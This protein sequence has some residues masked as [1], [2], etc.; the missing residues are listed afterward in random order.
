MRT[1]LL[2]KYYPV[3]LNINKRACLVAGGGNV[4][5]RKVLQLIRSGAIVKVVSP[6]VIEPIAKL[7]RQHKIKLV[8]RQYRSSDLSG[9]YLVYAATDDGSVNKKI[10]LDSRT[11]RILTNVV[12]SPA[13]CDFIMPAMMKKGKITITVSTDGFAPY[14][15]VLLKKRIDKLLDT[16]YMELIHI[17]IKV[18]SRLLKIKKS[19]VD[20]NIEHALDKLSRK[21]LVHYIKED[22]A[23]SLRRYLDNFILSFTGDTISRFS[24]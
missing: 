22:D 9:M 8:K 11:R 3:S 10:F 19:G 7:S 20:L 15:T 2:N 24:S 23:K 1:G 17:I 14:A 6:S 16:E 18:R 13:Y 5:Y 21:K 4:A 12:D